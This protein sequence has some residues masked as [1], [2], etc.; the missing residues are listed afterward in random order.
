MVARVVL[1]LVDDAQKMQRV[2]VEGYAGVVRGVEHFQHYGFTSSPLPGAE[3]IALAVG[4]ST[5][6]QVVINID[7]RRYRLKAMQGGEVA[8]Y[9]DLGQCAHFTRDGIVIKG[10]GLPMRFE[11][12][13]SI[14]FDTPNVFCTGNLF[15]DQTT[16]TLN[17]VMRAGGTATSSG[18]TITYT[19]TLITSNGKRIDDGHV[20]VETGT[21]TQP[22]S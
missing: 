10:A 19:G 9:D 7:D 22:P 18:G 16:S 17:Y 21:V 12:T 1:G 14:T 2:Q 8:L 11:D 4:G 15:V 20:H 6:H 13:P 5:N 3:G